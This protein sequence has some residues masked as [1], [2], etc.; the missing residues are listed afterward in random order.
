MRQE[1]HDFTRSCALPEFNIIICCQHAKGIKLNQTPLACSKP[2]MFII[3]PPPSPLYLAL[4]SRS[5]PG[6]ERFHAQQR[7]DVP[8]AFRT[9]QWSISVPAARRDSPA[10]APR[11]YTATFRI[12]REMRERSS[13]KLSSSRNEP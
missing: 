5:K 4:C 8:F 13:E 7:Y 3:S 12:R 6:C 2:R 11:I 10:A 1:K 9:Q